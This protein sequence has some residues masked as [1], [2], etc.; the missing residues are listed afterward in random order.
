[1]VMSVIYVIQSQEGIL[2]SLTKMEVLHGQIN[3]QTRIVK[4]ITSIYER[5]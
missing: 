3:V 5:K 2:L 1:M 4:H